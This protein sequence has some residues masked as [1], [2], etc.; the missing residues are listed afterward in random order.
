MKMKKWKRSTQAQCHLVTEHC[1]LAWMLFFYLRKAPKDTTKLRRS[2][3]GRKCTSVWE[4]FRSESLLAFS[5][6]LST[7]LFFSLLIFGRLTPN[8]IITC[9]YRRLQDSHFC[10]NNS[11]D[12]STAG[13]LFFSLLGIC[14]RFFAVMSFL[15]LL[16]DSMWSLTAVWR[17]TLLSGEGGSVERTPVQE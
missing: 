10:A 12:Q 15:F 14:I 4:T 5:T 8:G 7:L 13:V 9:H 1:N 6:F 11:A 3:S 16:C 2:S 17:I